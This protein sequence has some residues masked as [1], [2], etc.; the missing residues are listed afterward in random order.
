MQRVGQQRKDSQQPR[1]LAASCSSIVDVPGG[2][3]QRSAP[4]WNPTRGVKQA[5]TQETLRLQVLLQRRQESG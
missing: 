2:Q 4:G 1:G 3:F 5:F